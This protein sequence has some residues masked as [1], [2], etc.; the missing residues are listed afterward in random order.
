MMIREELRGLWP[1][2]RHDAREARTAAVELERMK[3]AGRE[4]GAFVVMCVS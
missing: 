4:S 1:E 3:E 2:M